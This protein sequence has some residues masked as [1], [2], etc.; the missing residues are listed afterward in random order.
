MTLFSDFKI[1]DFHIKLEHWTLS[2]TFSGGRLKVYLSDI[3]IDILLP[4]NSTTTKQ[5]E[6]HK[7]DSISHRNTRNLGEELQSNENGKYSNRVSI[8][9]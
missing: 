8:A 9:R 3:T 4:K 5:Y 7:N 6:V 1:D 2:T